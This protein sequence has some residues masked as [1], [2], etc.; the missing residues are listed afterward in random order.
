MYMHVIYGK[1][2]T[3]RMH[4]AIHGSCMADVG[5]AWLWHCMGMGKIQHTAGTYTTGSALQIFKT[6][7]AHYGFRLSIMCA[8]KHIVAVLIMLLKASSFVTTPKPQP[9]KTDKKP[10]K[11]LGVLSNHK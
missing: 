5:Y 2:A 8:S 1:L 3:C 7:H 11:Y 4:L 9:T 6:A 10:H